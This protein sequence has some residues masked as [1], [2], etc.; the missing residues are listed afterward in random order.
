MEVYW[1][2]FV[3]V[4]F[5]G[6]LTQMTSRYELVGGE[7]YEPRARLFMAILVFSV[8]IFFSGMRSS[9]AD[10]SV[11]RETFKTYPLLSDAN[12]FLSDKNLKDKG[13]A[14]LGVLVKTFISD[15]Y[16]VWFTIISVISG[17]SVALILYKYSCNFAVSAFLFMA[18]CQFTW[19]FNGIRQFLVASIMFLCTDLILKKKFM[20][21]ALIVCL[22]STIHQSALI[23]I[24]VYFI[25]TGEPWSKRTLLFVGGV[26]LAILFAG[27]FTNIFND[28]VENTSYS[29]AIESL[30][31]T[32]DGTNIV[33]VLVESVPTII[34]FIYR[35][36]INEKLTPIIKLSIN[37]S[38]MSTGIYVIS[39]VVS[40]GIM[41]GR[42]PI[43][44][45]MYNLILLPWLLKNIFYKKEKDLVYYIMIV[46]YF[47]FFYYQMC[48]T[49]G[50]PSYYSEILKL[51]YS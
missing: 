21:Y 6:I 4:I 35:D 34:A 30:K 14:F 41:I 2:M 36:K 11:Y 16:T 26:I 18:S 47:A 29:G 15:N 8:I 33:R 9:F 28:V 49:W 17:V 42:L 12:S 46:C 43:Y 1:F 31:E 38:L 7:T 51:R 37:M 22:L 27:V 5:F 10:T 20:I 25:V 39:K 40:S 50:G 45:S 44:F 48:I 32:D 19:M 24:P 3:W 23:L 13:F